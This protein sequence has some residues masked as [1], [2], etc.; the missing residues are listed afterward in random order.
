[1][2]QLDI[3]ENLNPVTRRRYPFAVVLQH[4]QFGHLPLIT[5]APLTS[6]TAKLMSS[7]LHPSLILDGVQYVLLAE[8]L[9]AVSR[10]TIG[11]VV[12]SAESSRYEIVAALDLLFTGV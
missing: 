2:R 8:E 3:V 1:M 7:R 6:A 9:A 5:V 11:R 4:D 12:G 10:P